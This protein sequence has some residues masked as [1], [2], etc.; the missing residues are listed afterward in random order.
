MYLQEIKLPTKTEYRL[1][2]GRLHN[3]DGPAVIYRIGYSPHPMGAQRYEWWIDGTKVSEYDFYLRTVR[4]KLNKLVN[5]LPIKEYLEYLFKGE[6]FMQFIED[7]DGNLFLSKEKLNR[8][9]QSG[10]HYLGHMGDVQIALD[11]HRKAECILRPA[12]L[13]DIYNFF[14]QEIE[15][16]GVELHDRINDLERERS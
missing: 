4:V 9:P 6:K 10:E 2:N 1:P 11:S 5:D 3:E 8:I 13:R 12:T 16:L 7:R 15:I 14:N